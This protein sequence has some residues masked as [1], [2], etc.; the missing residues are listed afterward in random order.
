M[1]A[2]GADTAARRELDDEALVRADRLYVDSLS[3]N[4]EVGDVA[5]AIS[6]HALATADATGELGALVDRPI[7]RAEHEST[8][9][10]LTGIGAQ[11]L[12]AAM[13][14][15]EAHRCAD[16]GSRCRSHPPCPPEASN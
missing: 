4:L 1:T 7:P 15:L 2:V 6:S 13:A 12:A 9:A 11:D 3:Q 14:V 8:V 5:A 16:L 10:K